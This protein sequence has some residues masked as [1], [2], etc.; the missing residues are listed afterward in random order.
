MHICTQTLTYI[1]T[2]YLLD[3]RRPYIHTYIHTYMYMTFFTR[4]DF[5]IQKRDFHYVVPS[6]RFLLL[7]MGS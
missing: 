6:R 5:P 2:T 3:S 4:L 7:A 1:S